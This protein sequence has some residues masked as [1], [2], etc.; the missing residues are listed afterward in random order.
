MTT[1]P[2]VRLVLRCDECVHC[3]TKGYVCQ[4]DSGSE[5]YCAATGTL[6]YIAD[7]S[8]ITPDW[9]PCRDEAIRTATA[10]LPAAPSPAKGAPEPAPAQEQCP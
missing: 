10:G 8:W 7:T 4:G 2:T 6:R 5:V 3:R 9:C 1:G